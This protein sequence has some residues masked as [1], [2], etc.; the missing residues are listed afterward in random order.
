MPVLLVAGEGGPDRVGVGDGS[1]LLASTGFSL[2][3][4]R[5]FELELAGKCW[6]DGC[7]VCAGSVGFAM[8]WG[9]C[10]VAATCGVVGGIALDER[11]WVGDGTGFFWGA[12]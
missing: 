5:E 3:L 7:S 8:G 11:G 1:R 12:T 9:F 10:D 6:V 4:S 2:R